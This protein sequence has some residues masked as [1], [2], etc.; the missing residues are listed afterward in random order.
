VKH[1]TCDRN[2][3]ASILK[4]Y[5][6]IAV[7]ELL[8][9]STAELHRRVQRKFRAPASDHSGSVPPELPSASGW[10][11][12]GSNRPGWL[13]SPTFDILNTCHLGEDFRQETGAHFYA[14]AH[15]STQPASSLK[16]ARLSLTYEDQGGSC[17]AEPSPCRRPQAR[18][19]QRRLPRLSVSPIDLERNDAAEW[20]FLQGKATFYGTEDAA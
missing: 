15:I 6:V 5:S 16:D 17:C 13:Q 1:I 10:P 2:F 19:S 7:I 4:F 14:K 3:R 12:P 18:L 20:L 8:V 9:N 11:H